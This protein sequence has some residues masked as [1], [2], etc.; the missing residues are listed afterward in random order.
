MNKINIYKNSYDGSKDLA[1]I[2][3]KEIN[4][5][6]IKAKKEDWK[7]EYLDKIVS[8]KTVNEGVEEAVDH[9]NNYGSGHTDAII[10]NDEKATEFFLINVREDFFSTRSRGNEIEP[11]KDKLLNSSSSLTSIIKILLRFSL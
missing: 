9:I 5:I 10:S 8:I 4:S 3:V 7:T 2:L 6:I 11:F 1:K